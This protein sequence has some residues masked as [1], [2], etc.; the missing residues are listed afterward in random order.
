MD[1]RR[2][3]PHN[4][5]RSIVR[6]FEERR[7]TLGPEGLTW[8]LTARP[9]QIID[10]YLGDPF[11]LRIDGG[12]LQTAA[13]TVVVGPQGSRRIQLYMSGEVH[14]FNILLQ[15]AA[16]NRLVGLDMTSLVNEGI[17]ARDVLGKSAVLLSGAVRSASDFDARVAAAERWFGMM[18]DDSP[19]QDGID[20]TSRLLLASRGRVRIDQLVKQSG[21]SARQFQRRFTVQVGLSPKLYARTVRFDAALTAHRNE[22]SKPWTGIIHSAGYFDQAHFIRECH[23]LVGVAPSQLVGDW[24]NIFSP[25]G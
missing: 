6:S 15:P 14:I 10:I 25:D 7:G 12:P 23:G 4:A 9:H 18:Q 11:R 2:R 17:P 20:Y 24:D 13:E 8:P 22:P 19:A 5:L 21:L 3:T 1:V 16:L